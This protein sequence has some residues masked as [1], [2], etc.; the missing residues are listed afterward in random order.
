[1]DRQARRARAR[2]ERPVVT[3]PGSSGEPPPAW[4]GRI[5]DLDGHVMFDG[6]VF[7]DLLGPEFDAE[8]RPWIDSLSGAITSAQ[9][10][11]ARRRAEEDVG[12]VRGFLALG[13]VDPDDRLLA[14]DRLGIDRQLVLPP[15]SWPTLDDERPGARATR[16]RYNDWMTAW[17][18]GSDRLVPAGA[19]RDAR[20]PRRPVG[21]GADRRRR[22]PRRRGPVRRPTGWMLAGGRRLGPAL[23]GAGLRVDR[24]GPPSRRR[25]RRHRREVAAPLHRARVVRT[26]NGSR[27]V[28]SR[29][30]WRSSVRTPW[31]VALHLRRCIF[32]PR[33]S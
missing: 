22:L 10:A 18:K 1:M 7:S 29:E 31:R 26:P 30:G 20:P 3:E 24:G 2:G 5:L 6:E 4:W 13:A 8:I 17:A 28:C 27:R 25:R 23:G 33:C 9:R 19:A 11:E 12:S 15:V 16:Q 32:L 14:L 21:G